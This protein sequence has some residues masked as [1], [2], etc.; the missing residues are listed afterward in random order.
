M[1]E[2]LAEK[3][4]QFYQEVSA[5]TNSNI[6]DLFNRIIDD[7]QASAN[8]K[9]EMPQQQTVGSSEAETGV[10]GKSEK[11]DTKIKL[12]KQSSGGTGAENGWASCCQR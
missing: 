12:G 4:A 8:K 10:S 2:D 1:S 11:T 6:E 5:K 3:Q 7:L 9:K